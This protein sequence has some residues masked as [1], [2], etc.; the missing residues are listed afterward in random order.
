[1]VTWPA[2]DVAEMAR[3]WPLRSDSSRAPK[4]VLALR[5][6]HERLVVVAREARLRPAD[7]SVA[8]ALRIPTA[9]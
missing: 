5:D 7:V 6:A 3:R 8:S 4:H 2:E 9:A 1:M